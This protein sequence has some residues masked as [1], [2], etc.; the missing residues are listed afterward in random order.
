M[1]K[2]KKQ[3]KRAME[4]SNKEIMLIYWYDIKVMECCAIAIASKEMIIMPGIKEIL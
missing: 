4:E 2:K 3:N 1:K